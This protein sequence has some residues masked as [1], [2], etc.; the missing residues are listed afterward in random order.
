MLIVVVRLSTWLKL[1][2][3]KKVAE[4]PAKI[5]GTTEKESKDED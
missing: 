5:E 3:M 2:G 1:A 4:E